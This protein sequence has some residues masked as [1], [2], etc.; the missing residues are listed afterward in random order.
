MKD[1]LVVVN[2]IYKSEA[3]M[4]LIILYSDSYDQ[5]KFQALNK[6]LYEEIVPRT[7]S[8]F[9]IQIRPVYML[10]LMIQQFSKRVNKLQRKNFNRV[11]EQYLKP[12]IVRHPDYAEAE[13]KFTMNMRYCSLHFNCMKSKTLRWHYWKKVLSFFFMVIFIHWLIVSYG[14]Y[15]VDMII[16]SSE[17]IVYIQIYCMLLIYFVKMSTVDRKLE[18]EFHRDIRI[19]ISEGSDEIITALIDMRGEASITAWD[20]TG[21]VI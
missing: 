10:V 2:N 21:R 18:L 11:F 15:S 20:A 1:R 19:T 13:L 4:R 8:P 16:L 5:I 6:R 17:L 3:I 14:F 12:E 9:P 7:L